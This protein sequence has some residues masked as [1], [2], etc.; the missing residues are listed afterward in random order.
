MRK[1]NALK[2]ERKPTSVQRARYL[3]DSNLLSHLGKKG[4]EQA[5]DN[6]EARKAQNERVIERRLNEDKQMRIDANEHIVPIDSDDER[7]VA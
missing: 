5:S 2:H 3:G 6:R 4:A 7:P 1:N